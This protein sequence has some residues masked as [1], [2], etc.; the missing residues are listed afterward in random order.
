MLVEWGISSSKGL[1][2]SCGTALTF[3]GEIIRAFIMSGQENHPACLKLLC[4]S[5][6]ISGNVNMG[7]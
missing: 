1:G 2:I 4:N 6:N 5:N 7:S 3:R